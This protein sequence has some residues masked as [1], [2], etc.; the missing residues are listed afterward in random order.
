MAGG[1]AGGLEPADGAGFLW[2]VSLFCVLVP[3]SCPG[4]S[5]FGWPCLLFCVSRERICVT[6][7]VS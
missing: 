1:R 6:Q 2:S 4:V 5:V 7:C 3:L